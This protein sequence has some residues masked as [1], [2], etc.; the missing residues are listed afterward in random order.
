MNNILFTK[1]SKQTSKKRTYIE[2]AVI[3]CINIPLSQLITADCTIIVTRYR[4]D[5][6]FHCSYIESRG[7]PGKKTQ[8]ILILAGKYIP[9]ISGSG[10]VISGDEIPHDL[11]QMI[12][13]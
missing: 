4:L 13:G 12:N 10:D 7:V 1:T 6:Q 9:Y 8:E 5:S 11:P 2:N 3:Y